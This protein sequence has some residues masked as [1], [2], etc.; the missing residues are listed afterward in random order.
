MK[1]TFQISLL[2]IIIFKQNEFY[3]HNRSQMC[4]NHF[5]W[6]LGD[7]DERFHQW[8]FLSIVCR[9]FGKSSNFFWMEILLVIHR[10]LIKVRIFYRNAQSICWIYFCLSAFFQTSKEKPDWNL[11]INLEGEDTWK[12]FLG[13]RRDI[14]FIQMI[15][16]FQFR[17][18]FQLLGK[19]R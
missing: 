18:L 10:H 14:L 4:Q 12:F 16:K 1:Y 6:D 13:H 3:W 17:I 8:S 15:R 2:N 19:P 7:E 11:S 9:D 5:C